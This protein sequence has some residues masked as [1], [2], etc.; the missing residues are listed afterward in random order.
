MKAGRSRTG[1]GLCCSRGGASLLA[2]TIGVAMTLG[3]AGDARAQDLT[4]EQA[5]EQLDSRNPAEVEAAIQSFG[6]SGS[7]RAVEPLS[8]RIRRGLPP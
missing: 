7:P 2:A 6:L 4:I 8:A 1:W 3:V 5:I